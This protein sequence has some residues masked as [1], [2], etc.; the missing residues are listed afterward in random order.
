MSCKHCNSNSNAFGSF[1]SL[2]CRNKFV[3]GKIPTID[4]FMEKVMPDPNSGCWLW[5]GAACWGGYGS[6][7]V[8]GKTMKAH[9][10]SYENFVGQIPVGMDLMHK[11]DNTFCVNPS[12]LKPGTTKE[13]IEDMWSKGRGRPSKGERNGNSKLTAFGVSY[14][15]EMKSAGFSSSQIAEK[16]GVDNTTIRRIF[17]GKSWSKSNA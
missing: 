13:N 10:F 11:C 9:R 12:H 17:T 1:C 2:S 8:K 14:I 3:A 5:A 15:K 4:R 7:G 6:I 16:F